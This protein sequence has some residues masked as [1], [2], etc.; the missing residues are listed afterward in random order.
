MKLATPTHQGAWQSD[1]SL[2]NCHSAQGLRDV[3]S[4]ADAVRMIA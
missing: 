1:L 3:A 4:R 2:G